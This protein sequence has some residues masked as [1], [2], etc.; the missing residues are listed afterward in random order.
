MY[1]T[2]CCIDWPQLQV[3]CMK[4]RFFGPML[5]LPK[6]LKED[7]ILIFESWAE[8]NEKYAMAKD[9]KVGSCLKIWCRHNH[10]VFCIASGVARAATSQRVVG[11]PDG[12]F[13]SAAWWG[14]KIFGK[15]WLSSKISERANKKPEKRKSINITSRI[16]DVL[17]WRLVFIVADLS[18]F[19]RMVCLRGDGFPV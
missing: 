13:Y 3:I 9:A 8:G 10:R 7:G 4:I 5:R 19:L 1:F 11:C 15:M 14:R 2:L 16:V 6:L 12:T 17:R 18:S